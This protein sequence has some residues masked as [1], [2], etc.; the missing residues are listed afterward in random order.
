MKKAID[1]LKQAKLQEDWELVD[2][3]INLL[4]KKPTKA[5]AKAKPI[6]NKFEEFV[7]TLK[8]DKALEAIDDNVPTIPRSRPSARSRIKTCE[9]G[10]RFMPTI[11]CK[12]DRCEACEARKK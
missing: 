8:I 1:L 12:Q 7:H 11:A 6:K 5:K 2:R 3:A 10:K 4:N 9:C